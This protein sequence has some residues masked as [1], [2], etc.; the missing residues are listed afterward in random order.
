MIPNKLMTILIAGTLLGASGCSGTRLRNLI[1][2]SDYVSLEELEAQDAAAEAIVA[3]SEEPESSGQLVSSEQELSADDATAGEK[4]KKSWFSFAALLGRSSDDSE[5]GPD[6]FVEVEDVGTEKAV[7]TDVSDDIDEGSSATEA[8]VART[9]EKYSATM[10]DIE[11]QAEGLVDQL[12]AAEVEAAIDERVRLPEIMPAS[13]TTAS[14][15]QS[16][17]DFIAQRDGTVSRSV[18]T[19]AQSGL[20][21]AVTEAKPK[22]PFAAATAEPAITPLK[23]ADK[24][25]DFDRLFGEASAVADA[26]TTEIPVK[27]AFTSELFP[28]L[29]ALIADSDVR[30]S[31]AEQ[32]REPA[33][34]PESDLQNP[35]RPDLESQDSAVDPFQQAARKHGFAEASRQD[36]WA[37]FTKQEDDGARNNS[38]VEHN[39]AAGDDEFFWGH[40][41]QTSQPETYPVA[42]NATGNSDIPLPQPVFQPVSSSDRPSRVTG[43]AQLSTDLSAGLTIPISAAPQPVPGA[44]EQFAATAAKPASWTEDPF[45]VSDPSDAD[46]ADAFGATMA[47]AAPEAKTGSSVTATSGWPMRTWIFLVGFAVVAYLLFAPARQNHPKA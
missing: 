42:E 20:T 31:A 33:T 28:E 30:P 12:A 32:G 41:T 3:E 1:T 7:S 25:S 15:Q 43:G 21:E 35:P 45:A 34:S 19:E 23:K 9:T 8:A 38:D 22:K 29:G 13:G 24:L 11:D 2:R 10:T 40:Q 46:F 47:V 36:P 44:I 18:A 14:G 17:A 39:N 26:R 16:F 37:A 5:L 27:D 4:K 6:P